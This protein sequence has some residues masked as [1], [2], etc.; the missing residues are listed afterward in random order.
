M[1][2]SS[3]PIVAGGRGS[4]PEVGGPG[5]LLQYGARDPVRLAVETARPRDK[6][7]TLRHWYPDATPTPDGNFIFTDEAGKKRLF[8]RSGLDV[9]DIAGLTRPAIE[10]LFSA[11]GAAVG[12]P[13]GI[14]GMLGGAALGNIAGGQATDVL[15]SLFGMPQAAGPPEKA[16]DI[17]GEVVTGLTSEAGGMALQKLLA[18]VGRAFAS[19]EAVPVADAAARLGIRPSVGMVSARPV[20]SVENLIANILPGSKAAREQVRVFNEVSEAARGA[21]PGLPG[22]IMEGREAAGAALKTGAARAIAGSSRH[23]SVWTIRFTT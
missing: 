10:T 15:M 2:R 6:L 17:A 3:D 16:M 4:D 1:P 20:S 8:N 21:V 13:S 11:G 5:E 18:P 22:G 12:A 9:G 7:A 23:G 14:P 19:P